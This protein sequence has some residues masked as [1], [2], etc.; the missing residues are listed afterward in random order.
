[1]TATEIQKELLDSETVLL[2]YCLG[3][4]R[5]YVWVVS[6][7]RLYSYVLPG[8]AAIED[9]ARRV[10]QLLQ[11]KAN[12]AL[13]V[14]SRELSAMIFGEALSGLKEK[15]LLIV[16][17]GELQRVPF[18]MLPLPEAG[19]PL[20]EHFEVVL[21]P[22]ASTV[23]ALRMQVKARKRAPKLLAVFADPVFEASDPRAKGARDQVASRSRASA[24][25]L[26]HVEPGEVE[27]AGY[28]GPAGTGVPIAR[29]PW[30]ANE[31][32]AIL[33]IAGRGEVLKAVGFHASRE[34]ALNA[35]LGE[36]RYL[37][38]A[39]HG[40]LDTERPALSALVL[41]QRDAGGQP[42]DG[43]LRVSDIYNSRLSADVVSLSACQT[44]L[45]KEVRGEGLMGLTRAFLYAGVPHVV[46]SLWNVNDRATA[47]LMASFYEKMLRRGQP[48][49]Q[50][51]REAQQEMRKRKGLASPYYWAAFVQQGDWQ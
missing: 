48:P 8:R 35:G 11:A 23:A 18:A 28:T 42:V 31:A 37:H 41:S 1:L 36:Y 20:V 7:E 26:A 21:A 47:V 19:G 27:G 46:V 33:R 22:S 6:Q 2:E 13:A 51:L 43:F 39:T 25:V 24:R 10:S 16:P 38:F 32:D 49:S 14:A 34:S 44:G 12:A 4:E 29:L 30:T 5:S 45:G 9:Q 15:R 40:Y 50:A 17:D 3:D